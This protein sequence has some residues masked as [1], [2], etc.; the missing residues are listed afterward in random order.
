MMLCRLGRRELSTQQEKAIRA[1][2]EAVYDNKSL[3]YPQKA[4][5]KAHPRQGAKAKRRLISAY[6]KKV[7]PKAY[8]Q[9]LYGE[10]WTKIPEDGIL[11]LRS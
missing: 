6:S 9:L 3:I 4:R 2:K 10:V 7:T 1:E 8:L 5:R 11:D